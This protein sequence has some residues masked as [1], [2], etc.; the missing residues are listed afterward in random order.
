MST[1]L[2]G[3]SISRVNLSVNCNKSNS[4]GLIYFSGLIGWIKGIIVRILKFYKQLET[5]LK[6]KVGSIIG[7]NNGDSF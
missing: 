1:W 2:Q 6:K 7:I 3:K 4:E 5:W